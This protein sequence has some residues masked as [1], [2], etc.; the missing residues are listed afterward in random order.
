MAATKAVASVDEVVEISDI[1]ISPRGRKAEFDNE[2]LEKIRNLPTD[3]GLRLVSM[4]VDDPTN[5]SQTQT[6][7]GKIR[8]HWREVF[9]TESGAPKPR[10]D[11]STEGVPQLRH[12]GKFV[13]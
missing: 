6:V 5:K 13:S 8:K 9:G 1:Q 11:F 10:I 7:G 2:L 3:K 12:S 4:Q